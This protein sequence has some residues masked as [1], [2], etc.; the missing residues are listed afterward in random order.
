MIHDHGM[1]TDHN[2]LIVVFFTYVYPLC[3][4][5]IHQ[6]RSPFCGRKFVCCKLE[7]NSLHDLHGTFFRADAKMR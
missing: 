4:V 7:L 3:L 2:F 6:L 5:V 1:K